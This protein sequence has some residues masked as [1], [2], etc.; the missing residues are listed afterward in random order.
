MK[1]G[2]GRTVP[3]APAPRRGAH[4]VEITGFCRITRFT[5]NRSRKWD[6]SPFAFQV[7]LFLAWLPLQ[8]DDDSFRE[9]FADPATRDAALAELVP[10]TREAWFHTA[11]AHQLAGREDAF[12]QTL[13]AWKAAPQRKD[14]PVSATGI[15]VLENR[16]L[17]IAYQNNPDRALAAL[18]HKLDLKFDAEQPNATAAAEKF[19]TEIQPEM[20][21]EAAFETQ[22]LNDAQHPPYTTYTDERLFRELDQIANFDE[23]QVRWF[24]NHLPR[25]DLPGVVPLVARILQLDRSLS[26]TQHPFLKLLTAGQL[27]E[28]RDT[29]PD[30]LHQESFVLAY[31]AKHRPGSETNFDRDPQAHA[32]HLQFC[33]DFVI[34]LSPALNSLKAHLLFHH[35][36]LQAAAGSYLKEDFLTFLALP[37]S[38]HPLLLGAKEEQ[39]N[40]ISLE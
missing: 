17:L 20:I 38:S 30:L 32:A 9:R 16:A 4:G 8:A 34:P 22:A 7:W 37:R 14:H 2:K 5:F 28:L 33:R 11:L 29:Q 27:E 24:F 3:S 6:V 12:A 40:R 31:L 1:T 26:F 18:I 10:D 35:L 13:E 23:S 19:P 36:R 25:V 39:L 21:S 15:E